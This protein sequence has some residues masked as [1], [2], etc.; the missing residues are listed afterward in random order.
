M[1]AKDELHSLK[2]LTGLVERCVQLSYLLLARLAA[3]A[4]ILCLSLG[5]LG[6]QLG[7]L[8]VYYRELLLI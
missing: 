8:S 2:H 3:Q 4:S 1:R 7:D 5:K 6:A